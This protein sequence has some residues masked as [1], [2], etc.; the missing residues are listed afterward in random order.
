MKRLHVTAIVLGSAIVWGVLLV[1]DGV[2]VQLGWIRHLSTV[3]GIVALGVSAF[4]L[5][6][7]RLPILRGWFVK[8]PNVRGTWHA[9]IRSTFNSQDAAGGSDIEAYVVIKQSYSSII[10]R[11]YTTEAFSMS[12]SASIESSSDGSH[13]LYAIYTN[14]P[15]ALLRVR[16]PIHNGAIALRVVGAPPE[17]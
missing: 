6:V 3:A 13:V 12:K 1:L 17:R 16:S 2:G 8:V 14:E 5:Y 9:T 10:L 4:D 15:G 7:W 11:L